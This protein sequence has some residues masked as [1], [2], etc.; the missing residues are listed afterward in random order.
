MHGPH[1]HAERLRRLRHFLH[2]LGEIGARVQ[3][4]RKS[5]PWFGFGGNRGQCLGLEDIGARVWISRTSGPGFRLWGE[6]LG[7]RVQG[8]GRLQDLILLLEGRNSR[9]QY[10]MRARIEGS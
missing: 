7:V 2:L 6:S 5:G 3:V 9:P 8:S 1:P 10:R 4:W